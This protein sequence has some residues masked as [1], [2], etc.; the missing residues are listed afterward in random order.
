MSKSGVKRLYAVSATVYDALV[1]VWNA[2]FATEAEDELSNFLMENLDETRIILEVGCGTAR[3]LEKIYSLNLK[4]KKYLGM[5]FSPRMLRVARRKFLD[6]PAVEFEEG[7]ITIL[8]SIVERFDIILCTWVLS[9]I[10]SPSAFVN[11]AQSLLKQDGKFF[12]ILFTRPRW[13]LNF[14]LSPIA[15]YLFSTNAGRRR[16]GEEIQQCEIKAQLCM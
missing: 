8:D 15:T 12:L 7:D 14:W 9:H 11:R 5:D 2:F 1:K 3:N 13:Y 4:F 10:E 16:R 6:N